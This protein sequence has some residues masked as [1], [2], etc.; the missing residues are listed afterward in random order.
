MA[1]SILVLGESLEVDSGVVG[2]SNR[3]AAL[4]LA[5]TSGLAAT[6]S[7]LGACGLGLPALSSIESQKTRTIQ[8]S[9]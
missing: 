4:D 8:V 6:R 7:R 1:C 9:T 5:Q 2:L 3:F